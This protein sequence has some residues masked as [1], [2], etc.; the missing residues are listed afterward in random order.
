MKY[1]V[2]VL[3][4][5]GNQIYQFNS[6]EDRAGFIKWLEASEIEYSTTEVDR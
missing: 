4:E 2:A 1:L 6:E 3:L 5:D